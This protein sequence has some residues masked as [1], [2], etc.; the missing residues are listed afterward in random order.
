MVK[1][2]IS[3]TR[4]I[5]LERNR[6]KIFVHF[7]SSLFYE[8]VFFEFLSEITCCSAAIGSKFCFVS[9]IEWNS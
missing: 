7:V 3:L 1:I 8:K 5:S 9:E 4:S 6:F 2:F